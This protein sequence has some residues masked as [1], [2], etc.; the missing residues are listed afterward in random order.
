LIDLEKFGAVRFMDGG[1]VWMHARLR[2][3]LSGKFA[4]GGENWGIA[5]RDLLGLNSF[6][7]RWYG[8]LLLATADPLAANEAIYHS[9]FGIEQH[10]RLV[11]RDRGRAEFSVALAM[12]AHSRQILNTAAELWKKRLSDQFADRALFDTEVRVRTALSAV[13][14]LGDVLAPG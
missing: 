7:A 11:H 12:V 9:L 3:D 8:R 2:D 10:F 5:A 4:S 14:A 13:R 6:V 1:F